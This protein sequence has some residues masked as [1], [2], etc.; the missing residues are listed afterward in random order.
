MESGIV[1]SLTKEAILYAD[2]HLLAV[3]KP[4]GLLTQ[5]SGT[6]R[7]SL[8]ELAKRWVKE[9]YG[10]PGNVF[11]EAVHRIDHEVSGVV[12][13]ARTSKALSRMNEQVRAHTV[14][15]IYQALLEERPPSD[16]GELIHF[17]KHGSHRAEVSCADDSAAK[18]ARLRYRV[19][20]PSN[21]GR[22]LVEIELLT[23]R[24]HQIRAQCA[25]IGTPI[26]GD[27]KYGAKKRYDFEGIA[28]HH[29]C[30]EV[31]HPVRG[32]RLTFGAPPP[33]GWGDVF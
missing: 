29:R 26:W 10:K 9:Q 6:D 23:G 16:E 27:V 3:N 18:E 14:R 19:L 25:A 33:A 1:Q 8:E 32:E 17:L 30:L 2:N 31:N 24:Y 13:F 20:R 7:V 11:L 22:W 5:P 28:L 4:A 15:K 12:L 21:G